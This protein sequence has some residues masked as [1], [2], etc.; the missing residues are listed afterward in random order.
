MNDTV[1]NLQDF[2]D[3]VAD[4]LLKGAR[5]KSLHLFIKNGS[6]S[7]AYKQGYD[8]GLYLYNE[9]LDDEEEKVKW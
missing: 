2:K 1:I 9:Q 3:G 8:F 6:S 4:G 5:H 7:D